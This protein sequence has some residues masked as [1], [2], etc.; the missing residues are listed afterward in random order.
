MRQRHP[1]LVRDLVWKIKDEPP[2]EDGPWPFLALFTRRPKPLAIPTLRCV[3]AVGRYLVAFGSVI[4][5]NGHLCVRTQFR[6]EVCASS[7]HAELLAAPK[8]GDVEGSGADR[9]WHRCVQISVL[10]P[11]EHEPRQRWGSGGF[12]RR[13]GC[14]RKGGTTAE[15]CPKCATWPWWLTLRTARVGGARP[16]AYTRRCANFAYVLRRFSTG[17]ASWVLQP[18]TCPTHKHG[19]RP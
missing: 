19:S 13:T 12:P 10:P 6:R 14:F 18:S 16:V 5:G 2:T 4:V 11:R 3:Q 1:C 9:L 8:H 7:H 17:S 15:N